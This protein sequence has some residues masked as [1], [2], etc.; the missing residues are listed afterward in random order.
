MSFWK[1][2]KAVYFD[3]IFLKK[4]LDDV[5]EEEERLEARHSDTQQKK[6]RIEVRSMAQVHL[7]DVIG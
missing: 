4:G 3:T 7:P 2:A 5:E 6:S 1:E